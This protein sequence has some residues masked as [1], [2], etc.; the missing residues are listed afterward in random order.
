LDVTLDVTEQE[1]A[2]IME[3]LK[4]SSK[5][6]RR[7]SGIGGLNEG[8]GE[9]PGVLDESTVVFA[10]SSEGTSTKPGVPDEEE[11]IHKDRTDETREHSNRDLRV[12]KLE[13][14]VFELKKT[15]YSAAALASI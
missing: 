9:I 1:V 14:D 12:T 3:A 10:T 5:T 15:N 6:S 8:I 7:Q 4:E 2:D 11:I 13:Q